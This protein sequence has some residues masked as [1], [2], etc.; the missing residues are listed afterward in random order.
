VETREYQEAAAKAILAAGNSLLV[1]PTA[2]GKTFVAALVMRELHGKQLFLAPTK[3]L[4]VQQAR[5]L[6]ELVG[7]KALLVTGE[8]PPAERAAAYAGAELVVAT[9]QCIENDLLARRIE[10]KDFRLVVFD[11]AHRAIGDYAY[12]FI[13]KQAKKASCF[14]LGLTASPSSQKQKII[15]VCRNLGVEHVEVKNA[16]DARGYVPELTLDWEFV[17]LPPE[18]SRLRERLRHLLGE[19]LDEL[20]SYGFLENAAVSKANKR[21]LLALRS[22]ILART[23]EPAAYKAMSAQAR[24]LNLS[25][26][27]DLLESQ[28]AAALNE[29]FSGMDS[30]DKKSKAVQRLLA[31]P[32]FA[33]V[34]RE[35]RELVDTGLLHPKMP[36][37]SELVAA[38]TKRGESVIVFAHYRASVDSI[39][40]ALNALPGVDARQLVGRGNDGMTQKQQA[41]ALDAFRNREFNVLVATSVGEEGLD[42]PAV[43]LVVFYE[44]VPS[45]IRLIQRRGRAGRVKA[46][47]VL[48]LV[49][50]D[51]KDEGFLWISRGKE[52]RM[53]GAL[54]EAERE[55]RTG[56]SRQREVTE[57]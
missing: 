47:R 1:M 46:G 13:G 42:V 22:A 55:L 14:V 53:P 38:A 11:E 24:A 40:A 8:V 20:K 32:L 43:D 37:L 39:E 15:Q 26:A 10:L 5:R 36:R 2:M 35:T 9:P 54:R 27:I 50:R 7:K 23:P 45:E 17:N 4:A 30:R 3:P 19:A 28:G 56:G 21:V 12:V 48:L 41:A 57:F 33:I 25:H 29:F 52:K 31:D 6:E 44:A 18:L 51:T 16:E 49:T 34:R